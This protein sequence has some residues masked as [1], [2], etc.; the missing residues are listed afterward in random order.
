MVKEKIE[1]LKQYINTD[2]F[3]L[4]EKILNYRTKY[5][6]VVLEDV[7]QPHNASAVLRTCDIFGIQDIHIIENTNEFKPNRDISMGSFK[8]LNIKKYNGSNFN[9]LNALNYLKNNGYRIVATT[10]HSENCELRNFDITKGKFA[11]VFGSERPGITDFVS[12]NADEFIKIDMYGFTQSFNI[13]VSVAV[14]LH[15]L[16]EKLH[17]SDINWHLSEQEHDEIIFE[18]LKIN[19]T[20]SEKILKHYENVRSREKI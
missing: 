19:I 12:E 10:P 5:A 18:W 20:N 15:E 8:W 7:F 14:I 16:I 4:F 2:R 11:L 17:D 3:N 9:T 6:T 1:Y 13:S